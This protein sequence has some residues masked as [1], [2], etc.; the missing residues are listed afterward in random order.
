MSRIVLSRVDLAESDN[1][2]APD[3]ILGVLGPK[4][5]GVP[6][7]MAQKKISRTKFLA[8]YN[9]RKTGGRHDPSCP[10][11]LFVGEPQFP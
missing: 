11:L 9:F 5:F 4:K 1:F 3:E 7:R 10:T 8:K 6:W 2:S